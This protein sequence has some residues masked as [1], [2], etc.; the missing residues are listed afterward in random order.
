LN[1]T[2]GSLFPRP[3]ANFIMTDDDNSEDISRVNDRIDAVT[4]IQRGL[5]DVEAG[6]TI[7]S[8]KFFQEFFATYGIPNEE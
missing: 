7:P 6:R 3:V 1:K 8:E 5:A 2:D 4:G